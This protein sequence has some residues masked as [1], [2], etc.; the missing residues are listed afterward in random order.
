MY[1]V[2]EWVTSFFS[3]MS[4]IDKYLITL[5]L[6]IFLWVCLCV[7]L[8]FHDISSGK[9]TQLDVPTMNIKEAHSLWFE[10]LTWFLVWVYNHKLQ[11]NFEIHSGWMIFGQLTAIGLWNLAKYLVVSTFFIC[12][13]HIYSDL[14][15]WPNDPKINKMLYIKRQILK[16]GLT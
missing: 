12:P 13:S 10:I 11:I 15:L 8:I 3:F 4:V 6:T 9:K 16:S 14:D 2:H 1:R 5:F 7:C